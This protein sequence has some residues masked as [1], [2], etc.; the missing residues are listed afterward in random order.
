MKLHIFAMGMRLPAWINDGFSDYAKR[1]PRNFQLRLTELKP[2]P[3]T[4]GK[5][6]SQMLEAEAQ[7]FDAA[8]PPL[9]ERIALDERG[10]D[11]TTRE[12]ASW[13]DKKQENGRD[14]ALMIGG[15][16]GLAQR[17]KEGA[18]QQLRLSR[19][20]L[21]HGLARVLLAEQ[22]YRAISLLQNHPYHRD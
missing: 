7:R 12:L 21:P 6:V 4:T 9:C 1:M 19:M 5:T 2:E 22:L 20:T 14:I 8:I 15:P 17:I 10:R 13:L 16:D 11:L 18:A 3:R